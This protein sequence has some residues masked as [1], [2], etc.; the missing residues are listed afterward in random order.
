VEAVPWKRAASNQARI[1]G[2]GAGGSRGHDDPE[3]A[4]PIRREEC[5]AAVRC[6]RAA[7]LTNLDI[8]GFGR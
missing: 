1:H 4:R 2:A 6:A 3:I 5:E 8:Q 7:G